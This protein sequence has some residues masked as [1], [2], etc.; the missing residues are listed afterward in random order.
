MSEELATREAL[1]REL[2]AFDWSSIESSA[3]LQATLDE[4]RARARKSAE[5]RELYASKSDRGFYDGC[6]ECEA[7]SSQI[8]MPGRGW[9]CIPCRD[10]LARLR[11]LC[12]TDPAS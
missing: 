1:I 3:E 8:K 4:A 2:L 11:A 12:A 5:L 7:Q 6:V 10:A 9:V